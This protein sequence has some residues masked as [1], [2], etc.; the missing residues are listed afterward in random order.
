MHRAECFGLLGVNGAGKTTTF[1]MLTGDEKITGGEAFVRGI[2]LK[3]D[4]TE[5]HK[6]IGYCPQFDALLD[7]LTGA[8]TLK[9]FALLRGIDRKDIPT[10]SERLAIDLKFINHINKKVG[11]YSGGNKRKLST[12]IAVMGDPVV[13]YLGNLLN[14]YLL[15]I[16]HF[17][18][19]TVKW[20]IGMF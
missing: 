20:H 2:S 7:D 15:K 3:S 16:E 1:K 17:L 9:V 8:E 13:V 12:A 11:E 10:L 6:I 18:S 5:V 19:I 4:M 14:L